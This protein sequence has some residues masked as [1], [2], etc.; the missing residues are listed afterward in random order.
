MPLTCRRPPAL[1]AV[2]APT[3]A[4]MP[5][6]VPPVGWGADSCAVAVRF[7]VATLAV[8]FGVTKAAVVQRQRQHMGATTRSTQRRRAILTNDIQLDIRQSASSADPPTCSSRLRRRRGPLCRVW[9]GPCTWLWRRLGCWPAR[10]LWRRLGRRT[11]RRPRR[12][13]WSW[14]GCGPCRRSGRR[15]RGGLWRWPWRQPW[16]R[17]GSR[18][19][20][21]RLRKHGDQ[22]SYMHPILNVD[23]P[24][25][26]A[27]RSPCAASSAA[28]GLSW[29]A[30]PGWRHLRRSAGCSAACT[31]AP[32]RWSSCGSPLATG[33]SASRL[34][35]ANHCETQFRVGLRTCDLHSMPA[36]CIEQAMHDLDKHETA[37][38]CADEGVVPG[39]QCRSCW[40]S[41]TTRTRS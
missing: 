1:P 41:S 36:Q 27:T 22:L 19:G 38:R 16:C 40:R 23:Q 12:R 6:A 24:G 26:E 9:C 3:G 18:L 32:S 11:R 7:T 39:R 35:P 34:R 29:Y 10:R 31:T 2:D 28:G 14:L 30:P 13:P 20:K 33:W 8:G 21:G 4:E 37:Q 17:L 25:W 5:A 15:L